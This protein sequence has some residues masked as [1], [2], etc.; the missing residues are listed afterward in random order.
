MDVGSY[1]TINKYVLHAS[2]L[3]VKLHEYMI[4]NI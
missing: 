2:F 4:L 3:Q 1:P